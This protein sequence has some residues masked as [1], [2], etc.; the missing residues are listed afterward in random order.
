MTRKANNN[1]VELYMHS[2]IALRIV[3]GSDEGKD[4]LKCRKSG[5]PVS[6]Y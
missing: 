4:P 2:T 1:W 5:V 6:R 3:A